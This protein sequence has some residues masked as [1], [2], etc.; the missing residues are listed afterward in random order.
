MD[1]ANDPTIP[2]LMAT[3]MT[4]TLKSPT[5]NLCSTTTIN[6][7]FNFSIWEEKP[8]LPPTNLWYA[9]TNL[10]KNIHKTATTLF[11]SK[12]VLSE[13]YIHHFL[14]DKGMTNGRTTIWKLTSTFLK[15]GAHY[16]STTQ[17]IVLWPQ[18]C[19]CFI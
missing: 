9:K 19:F 1:A 5:L 10:G 15:I 14:P 12:N 18:N 16:A 6:M 8:W 11:D 4:Q 2:S 3:N 7:S 17:S 13:F